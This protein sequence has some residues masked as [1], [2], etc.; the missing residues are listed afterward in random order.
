MATVRA[1]GERPAV[2]P[3][4][5]S[6]VVAAPEVS[7]R[8]RRLYPGLGDLAGGVREAEQVRVWLEPAEVLL[9]A[10]ATREAVT[11]RWQDIDCLYFAGHAVR[12]PEAPYRT[13]LPLSGGSGE[14]LAGDAGQLDINDIRGADLRRAR[15]VVLSGC[16]SG[17]PYVSGDATAP[18]L[19]DVFLDAGAGAV[20]QTLW[21]VRDDTSPRL[22]EGFLR[23]WRHDHQRLTVAFGGAQ[24][25]ALRGKTGVA[26]HPFGWAA[27]TL[28]LRALE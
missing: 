3:L 8:L 17:A 10:D 25:E 11:A 1:G 21:R 24:R 20:V 28:N 12:S 5:A 7:P 23:T 9:G 19:G 2:T 15:L 13:F 14:G 6:L 16:A 18:S 27:Y 4:A 26:L 22:L